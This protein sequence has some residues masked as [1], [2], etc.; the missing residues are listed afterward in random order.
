M[1]GSLASP[2]PL[3]KLM[4]VEKLSCEEAVETPFVKLRRNKKKQQAAITAA[5]WLLV[6]PRN[7][8][9]TLLRTEINLAYFC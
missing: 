7:L 8:L 2:N 5:L 6:A 1:F 3:L 4:A 9:R